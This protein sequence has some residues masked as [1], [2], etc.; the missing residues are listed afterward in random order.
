MP[1][2]PHH[3]WSGH[4]NSIWRRVQTKKLFNIKFFPSPATSYLLG[5]DIFLSTPQSNCLLHNFTSDNYKH[6]VLLHQDL[7]ETESFSSSKLKWSRVSD[8][9]NIH[10]GD[11]DLICV[12]GVSEF[13]ATVSRYSRLWVNDEATGLDSGAAKWHQ[14]LVTH[15]SSHTKIN[16]VYFL[17]T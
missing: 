6:T 12:A 11:G 16:N 15:L 2:A 1:S 4:P 7:P 9:G 14:I 17:C 13:A 5:P 3:S 10:T 8:F